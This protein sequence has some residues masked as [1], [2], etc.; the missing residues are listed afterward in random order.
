MTVETFLGGDL[1]D[2]LIVRG[3]FKT[4]E[5]PCEHDQTFEPPGGVEQLL[6]GDLPERLL[7]HLLLRRLELVINR[8]VPNPVHQ[9]LMDFACL[10]FAVSRSRMA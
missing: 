5:G 6:L 1:L 9:V 2:D 7:S 4:A 8:D 3:D 10:G